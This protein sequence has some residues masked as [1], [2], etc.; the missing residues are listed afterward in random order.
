MGELKF[1]LRV[2]YDRRTTGSLEPGGGKM[3]GMCQMDK[4][5]LGKENEWHYFDRGAKRRKK[6]S[7]GEGKTEMFS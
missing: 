6:N 7:R 5:L 1:E 4:G 3:R 2:G